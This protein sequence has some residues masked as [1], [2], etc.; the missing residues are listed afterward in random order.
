MNHSSLLQSLSDITIRNIVIINQNYLSGRRPILRKDE[1]VLKFGV[2]QGLELVPISLYIY[3]NIFVVPWDLPM[4]Q[5]F[6]L[7]LT[8]GIILKFIK[9]SVGKVSTFTSQY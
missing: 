7:L 4:K 6:S 3:N 9:Q 1:E 2:S 8:I 5:L